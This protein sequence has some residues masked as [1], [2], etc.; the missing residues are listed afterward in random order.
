MGRFIPRVARTAVLLTMAAA[1]S[2]CS[3]ESAAPAPADPLAGR[4]R[5]SFIDHRVGGGI[6]AL[7]ITGAQGAG[8]VPMGDWSLTFTDGP[9]VAGTAPPYATLADGSIAII[10]SCS[11]GT[12]GLTLRLDG[13]VLAGTYFSL[14]CPWLTSGVVT[15]SRSE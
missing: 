5:G 8:R 3:S 14:S 10:G 15:L 7:R 2:S 11:T 6:F 1:L 12:L 4:W 13:D 9:T